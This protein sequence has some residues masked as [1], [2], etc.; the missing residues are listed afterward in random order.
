VIQLEDADPGIQYVYVGVRYTDEDGK[1]IEEAIYRRSSFRGMY[2]KGS[3]Q[4]MIGGVLQLSMRRDG[5]WLE[6][7]KGA[8]TEFEFIADVIDGAGNVTEEG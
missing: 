7:I 8:T 6:L 4:S 3:T 2:V 5:G 1:Q